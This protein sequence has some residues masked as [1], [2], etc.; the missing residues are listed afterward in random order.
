MSS[1]RHS[2]SIA[3]SYLP[4]TQPQVCEVLTKLLWVNSFCKFWRLVGIRNELSQ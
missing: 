1:K 3:L 2:V 4:V